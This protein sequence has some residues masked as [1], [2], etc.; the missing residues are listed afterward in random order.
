MWTYMCLH[1]SVCICVYMCTHLCLYVSHL[2]PIMYIYVYVLWTCVYACTYVLVYTCP[3]LCTCVNVCTAAHLSYNY[4]QTCMC[5]RV[6]LDLMYLWAK[7]FG[8]GLWSVPSVVGLYPQPTGSLEFTHE[9]L[10]TGQK[11]TSCSLW[12]VSGSS[13]L[14]GREKR[15]HT[16]YIQTTLSFIQHTLGPLQ[17]TTDSEVTQAYAT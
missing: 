3:C 7:Y 14:S 12:A 15:H 16:E 11:R 5:M 10:T 13:G 4:V 8:L 1:V 2:C 9:N 6:S 17:S